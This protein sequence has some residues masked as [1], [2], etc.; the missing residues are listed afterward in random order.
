MIFPPRLYDDNQV[1]SR[2]SEVMEM[3]VYDAK[4]L[5]LAADTVMVKEP[6][7]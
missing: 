7:S 1:A 5:Y 4:P 6:F 3:P 2:F